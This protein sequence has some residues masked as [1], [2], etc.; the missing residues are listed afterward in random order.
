MLLNHT[1]TDRV[2]AVKT[3]VSVSFQSDLEKAMA[4]LLAAGKSQTRVLETPA[5][6]VWIS[7]I[8][9][10]GVEL[11][12]TV[13]IRDAEEGQGSL[14]SG[15]YLDVLHAFRQEGVEIPYPQREVRVMPTNDMVAANVD[16]RAAENR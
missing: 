13:W 16:L 4:L 8:G 14:R 1:Y 6:S 3:A 7:N 9:D 15:I 10:N 2:V 5:P 12:L 11:E